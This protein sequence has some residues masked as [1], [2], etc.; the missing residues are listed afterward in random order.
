MRSALARA[1]WLSWLDLIGMVAFALSGVIIARAHGWSLFGGAVLAI[2]PA[3]GG[4]M[5]R[6]MLADRHPLYVMEAPQAV[7][8]VLGV[9]LLSFAFLKILD[10]G[11][12]RWL[13]LFDAANLYVRL[14]GR[15]R[16]RTACIILERCGSVLYPSFSA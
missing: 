1:T 13:W 2:L 14:R 9:V 7:L 3:L 10:F 16:P 11:R 4:G 8:T 6:D 5:L 12:G 15:F